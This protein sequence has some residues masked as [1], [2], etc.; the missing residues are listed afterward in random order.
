M[1]R[2]EQVHQQLG[3]DTTL[4]CIPTYNQAV[5]MRVHIAGRQ[6]RGLL[7]KHPSVMS[8]CPKRHSSLS[9]LSPR[10]PLIF[11]MSFILLCTRYMSLGSSSRSH[12][13]CNTVY[14]LDVN[15]HKQTW[16]KL[17]ESE[18][19]F[20]HQSTIACTPTSKTV[21]SELDPR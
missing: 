1:L 15:A 7:A 19:L 18:S 10:I 3:C 6:C 13:S 11:Y 2:A 12:I 20:S 16:S 17:F 9:S 14:S 21:S 4:L 5:L 8:M